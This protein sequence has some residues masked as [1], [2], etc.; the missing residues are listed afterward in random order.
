MNLENDVRARVKN[1]KPF[2][3]E[4]NNHRERELHPWRWSLVFEVDEATFNTSYHHQS[5]ELASEGE[6]TFLLDKEI[7]DTSESIYLSITP[8]DKIGYPF[9]THFRIVGTERTIEEFSI[10]IYRLDS[11]DDLSRMRMF[12]SVSQDHEIDFRNVH[13]PDLIQFTLFLSPDEFDPLAKGLQAKTISSLNLRVSRVAGFY[14]EFSPGISTDEV[15]VLPREVSQHFEL[16]ETFKTTGD[17]GEFELTWSVKQKL[18]RQESD[19]NDDFNEEDIELDSPPKNPKLFESETNKLLLQI[20]K[21]ILFV[22][23]LLTLVIL[24]K[25]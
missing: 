12:S 13:E 14:S 1:G 21:T 15:K 17:V 7:H 8:S 5:E 9:G 22:G 23:I 2:L 10:L 20:K 19:C 25:L 3:L 11:D 18:V 16:Q 24:T 6:E 4:K